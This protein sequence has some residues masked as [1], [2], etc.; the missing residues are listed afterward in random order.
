MT[1]KQKTIIDLME[2]GREYFEIAEALNINKYNLYST[3]Y[4]MRKQGINLE[5]RAKN[6]LVLSPA[7]RKVLT[8][9]VQKVPIPE[10]AKE[11]GINCQTVMNHAS[12]GFE[13]LGLAHRGQDRI[14]A[15]RTI[16]ESPKPRHINVTMDDPFFN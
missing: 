15:L 2:K 4:Q 5:K 6:P 12:K 14:E 10:I 3:I 7:Q 16:L 8:H 11:L 1:K 13:R 9:Y